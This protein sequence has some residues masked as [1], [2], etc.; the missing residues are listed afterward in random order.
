M[1]T[2]ERSV[3]K[4]HTVSK[5]N[6]NPNFD[7]DPNR[8]HN[9]SEFPLVV[10]CALSLQ[11]LVVPPRKPIRVHFWFR[12]N[13]SERTVMLL[14]MIVLNVIRLMQR[15]FRR[16]CATP[17]RFSS[18]RLRATCTWRIC[19]AVWWNVEGGLVIGSL[20]GWT[21]LSWVSRACCTSLKIFIY[22]VHCGREQQT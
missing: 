4:V 1:T 5:P 20:T 21:L 8:N 18:P 3:N 2:K 17:D 9:F 13:Y 10:P 19:S 7:P 12:H 15:N 6:T 16:S 11:C 22:F 14:T